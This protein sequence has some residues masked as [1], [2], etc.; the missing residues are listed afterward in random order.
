MAH[1]IEHFKRAKTMLVR[2]MAAMQMPLGL[3]DAALAA[4][5]PY[6]SRGKGRNRPF[7]RSCLSR[8]FQDRSKYSPAECDR[9]HRAK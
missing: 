4:I 1:N 7:I 5:G 9:Q 2:V 6:V 3:R 8:R